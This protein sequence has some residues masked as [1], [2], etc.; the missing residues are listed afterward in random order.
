VGTRGSVN[1][2]AMD[3]DGNTF[4]SGVVGSVQL[5]WVN[6]KVCRTRLVMSAYVSCVSDFSFRMYIDSNRRN[7]QI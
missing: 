5:C 1:R 2:H 7:S 6:E 4:F 3:R